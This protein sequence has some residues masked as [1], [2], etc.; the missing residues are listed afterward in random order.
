MNDEHQQ[1]AKLLREFSQ[2]AD[3]A[4]R[5]AFCATNLLTRWADDFY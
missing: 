4:A 5:E 3:A 2:A 1:L